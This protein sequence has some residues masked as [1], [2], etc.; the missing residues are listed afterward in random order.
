MPATTPSG[1]Q[2][3][4]PSD[5]PNIATI[6]QNFATSIDQKIIPSFTNSTTRAAAITAPVDGQL[7]YNQATKSIEQY[8][9]TLCGGSWSQGG[10]VQ[11]TLGNSWVSFDGGASYP[12]PQ[13]TVRAGL[14]VMTGV[15]KSGTLAATV[16]TLPAGF[17][18]LKIKGF[19]TASNTA[20]CRIDIT[21]AGV[22]QVGAYQTGGS[23]VSVY[24]DGICFLAEQ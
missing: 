23:N 19:I 6:T 14:V 12:I 7:S 11:P 2:Y 17:R 13:Y 18:P 16:F 15:M 1:V 10:W 22:V 5:A 4:V 24:L 8:S 9:S 21:A 20:S 3:A